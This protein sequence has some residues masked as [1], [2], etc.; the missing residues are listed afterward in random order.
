MSSRRLITTFGLL[1][2][3]SA[4]GYGVMF[5]ALDDF[6]DHFGISGGQLSLVVA[7]GFFTQFFA[8]LF[9]A[10]LADRGH[11]RRLVAL[12]MMAEFD[13]K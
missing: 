8:Q 13:V 5:T 6:R 1:T 12:G 11:A 2:A 4:A 3:L 10:P 7:S 9:L